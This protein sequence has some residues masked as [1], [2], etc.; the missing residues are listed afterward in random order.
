MDHV[1]HPLLLRQ[2][3]GR[4]LRRARLH[5]GR[6]LREVATSAALSVAHLSE[7]ER[8]HNEASSEVLAA[9]C[10]ALHL[11]LGQVLLDAARQL[12][13]DRHQGYV[14]LAHRRPVRAGRGHA[15]GCGTTRRTTSSTNPY[16]WASSAVNH[17]SLSAS[18]TIRS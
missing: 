10:T 14:S 5:Q 11:Q 16:A 12:H 7:M 8:G 9:V 3:L 1:T 17:R 18:A 4:S 2:V 13:P 15:A 6:T